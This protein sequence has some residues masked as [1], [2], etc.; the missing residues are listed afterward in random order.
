MGTCF[1]D[2]MMPHEDTCLK[3][4]LEDGEMG[5]RM[6]RRTGAAV[7]MPGERGGEGRSFGEQ[8]GVR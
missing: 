5:R 4:A 7:W 8:Q 6:K 2:S 1:I 3:W